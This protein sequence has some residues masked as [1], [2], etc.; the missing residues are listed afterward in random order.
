MPEVRHRR[1]VAEDRALRRLHRLLELSGLQFHPAV[2]AERRRHEWHQGARRGSGDRPRSVAALRPLRPLSA[3]RR[4]AKVEKGSK[5]K[6]EKPK[7]AG[8]PKGLAPDDIDLEK[9]LALLALPREVGLSPEDGEPILAG[10]GRFGPYVKHGKTY[11]SLEEGD[12]VLTVG[13]NRAVT[14]IAEKIANPKKGRRFGADPGKVLGEHPDKG[15][16]IVVKNGR[17]GPYVS[18]NGVNAT[19]TGD[20]TPDTVTLDE[21]VSLLDARAAALGNTP[22]ARRAA[23]RKQASG[24]PAANPPAAAPAKSA[25]RAKKPASAKAKKPAAIAAKAKP[26]RRTKAAAE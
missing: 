11:A 18:H 15:G 5:E 9:A 3:A 25:A 16:S 1:A 12:D 2:D 10:V 17:Y 8:L 20:K 14:L 13:L 21:A 6:P 4:T 23:G 7:R 24:K 19:L 22:K 26:A